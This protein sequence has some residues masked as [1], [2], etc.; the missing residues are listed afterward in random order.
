MMDQLRRGPQTFSHRGTP[1]VAM[2]ASIN[3]A[4]L[5]LGGSPAVVGAKPGVRLN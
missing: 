2:H 4:I 1:N 5:R 3:S